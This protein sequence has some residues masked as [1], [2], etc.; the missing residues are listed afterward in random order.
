MQTYQRRHNDADHH[1]HATPDF[2]IQK[3]IYCGHKAV[4]DSWSYRKHIADLT[5]ACQIQY[6]RLLFDNRENNDLMT[7]LERDFTRH[8]TCTIDVP[9]LLHVYACSVYVFNNHISKRIICMKPC[10]HLSEIMGTR[11]RKDS[12]CLWCACDQKDEN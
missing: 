9:S 5:C 4:T 1:S 11:M 12:V 8:H 2:N 7:C 3:I 6:E 10:S